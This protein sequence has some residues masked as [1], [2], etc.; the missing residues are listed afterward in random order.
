MV[1]LPGIH[2]ECKR[3]EALNIYKAIEQAKN[4]AREDETPVVMHRKNSS[5][6]LVTMRFDDWMKLYEK[7]NCSDC[8]IYDEVVDEMGEKQLRFKAGEKDG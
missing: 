1:G 2:I 7:R 4:D 8:D 3:V 5:E 6:W